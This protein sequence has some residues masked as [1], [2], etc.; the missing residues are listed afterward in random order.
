MGAGA[1]IGPKRAFK[2]KEDADSVPVLII[3]VT[4][5]LSL[6]PTVTNNDPFFVL[7]AS[8]SQQGQLLKHAPILWTNSRSDFVFRAALTCAD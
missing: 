5:E 6:L 3:N 1:E 4:H 8:I 2:F 7:I